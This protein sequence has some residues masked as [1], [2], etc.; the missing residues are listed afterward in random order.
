[1]TVVE[2]RW[3]LP[4]LLL[5]A[6]TASAGITDCAQGYVFNPRSGVGCQQ[7]DCG[8]VAHS[9]YDYTGHCV[10]YACGEVGCSGDPDFGKG[11]VRDRGYA[12]CPGCLYMCISPD[13]RCP[14]ERPTQGSCDSYC[15]SYHGPHFS[16]KVDG[17]RC[18]CGCKEGYE[19]DESLVCVP[20]KA[21]CNKRCNEYHGTD[22]AHGGEAYGVVIGT[23]CDCR[24]KKGYVPDKTL[25]CV[26]AKSCSEV[27]IDKWGGLAKGSGEYPSCKCSCE[28]PL[29]VVRGPVMGKMKEQCVEVE[30]EEKDNRTVVA[31]IVEIG[32]AGGSGGKPL[33]TYIKKGSTAELEAQ[34]GME[35]KDGD[36]VSMFVSYENHKLVCN[37][38]VVIDWNGVRGKATLGGSACKYNIRVG[39]DAVASGWQSNCD[40]AKDAA[41][42]T[43]WQVVSNLPKNV[44]RY[45]GG[46]PVL[47]PV[48]FLA[49]PDETIPGDVVRVYVK[50]DIYINHTLNG[51]T[52]YTVDGAPIVE[53]GG[54]NTTVTK[55]MKV[56]V[57]AG[58]VSAPEEFAAGEIVPFM[59]RLSTIPDCKPMQEKDDKGV[60]ACLDGYAMGDDGECTESEGGLGGCFCI[61]LLTVLI[62][63]LSA[64]AS[65]AGRL[66]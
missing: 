6:S 12:A 36:E 47:A 14:G 61:P 43:F 41:S 20:T 10:C 1:L 28:P 5:L 31:K 55:G 51:M 58:S 64:A 21:E 60:C 19:G 29:K 34:A 59:D 23:E 8:D 30:E 44:A 9:F 26:K 62:S 52:L 27:C 42:T 15:K 24:C 3:I 66:I 13:D 17:D 45:L 65:K 7:K 46:D 22:K 57:T 56:V 50:S 53:S 2:V 4:A 33:I 48:T 11:C 18:D 25:T 38:Y 35:L 49:Q 54:K 16:A 63:L 37:P 40:K 39:M 32:C